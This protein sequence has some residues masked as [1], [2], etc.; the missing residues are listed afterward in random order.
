MDVESIRQLNNTYN[1]KYV[2]YAIENIQMSN[3][4][5]LYQLQNDLID[6]SRFDFTTR[7]I[8]RMFRTP[9]I[10][11]KGRICLKVPK[12]FIKSSVKSKFKRSNLYNQRLTIFDI[13]SKS[14]F[15]YSC[16]L[17]ID[18][19]LY[20]GIELY[21]TDDF[22]YIVFSEEVGRRIL[23]LE[24]ELKV[25]VII[26]PNF[27]IMTTKTN[28]YKIQKTLIE[29][30]KWKFPKS[31]KYQFIHT[32]STDNITSDILV[33]NRKSGELTPSSKIS[34]TFQGEEF[35]INSIGMQYLSGSIVV[36]GQTYFSIPQQNMP[37]VSE[38]M[39]IFK[40]TDNG[41]IYDHDAYVESFYPNIYR[42][43]GHDSSKKYYILFFY[44][45]EAGYDLYNKL[46]YDR[47]FNLLDRINYDVL[48]GYRTNTLPDIIKNYSPEEAVYTINEYNNSSFTEPLDYK[49]D[50]LIELIEKDS[51]NSS[52]YFD[53][54]F[55]GPRKVYLD[56]STV[57]LSTRERMNTVS[58]TPN[59]KIYFNT[60]H[61]V[62]VFR[63]G[64]FDDPFNIRIFIDGLVTSFHTITDNNYHTY[65]YLPCDCVAPTSIIEF[66]TFKNVVID[67]EFT[68]S[69]GEAILELKLP[70]INIMFSNIVITTLDG[71][72]IS[73]DDYDI[74]VKKDSQFINLNDVYKTYIT[75][76]F[77][78]K[79]SDNSFNGEKLL[80]KVIHQSCAKYQVIETEDNRGNAIYFKNPISREKGCFRIFRN[81]KLVPNEHYDIKYRKNINSEIGIDIL[82]DKQVG[83]IIIADILPFDYN[84]V[85]FEELI[86]ENGYVDLEGYLDRPMSLKW[87]DVYLNGRKLNLFNIDIISPTKIFIQGV[88]SRKN[89]MIVEIKRDPEYF[90]IKQRWNSFN[91]E[92]WENFPNLKEEIHAQHSILEDSEVDFIEEH[93]IPLSVDL[94]RF[95]EY[96]L[97][98]QTYINA[99]ETNIPDEIYDQFDLMK[100]DDV[101]VIDPDIYFGAPSIL[102]VF[103]ED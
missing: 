78:I 83:D 100:V 30:S 15:Q 31:N 82:I 81:G 7:D 13:E 5:Y 72:I 74:L 59:N 47:R 86:S 16:L 91:D 73:Y 33:T 90:S 1:P 79:F 2:Q 43:N 12:D 26:C 35:V 25:S 96:Y 37:I 71:E 67:D 49:D 64:I 94:D 9:Y 23:R 103:N 58:E 10:P 99:D 57:D 44:Y 17:F 28:Y 3:Y 87:Y 52:K 65:V 24:E 102:E 38:N 27:K 84:V 98:H 8:K 50:K 21:P 62:F 85:Y 53:L 68:V 18:G 66:E 6:Y 80:L 19:I 88:T 56:V 60:P 89:L 97:K 11:L 69:N 29:E 63:N 36:S 95:Y 93:V 40:K 70:D 42:L 51:T 48:N 92:L 20:T 32:L 45:D 22:T 76:E 77:K 41:L 14:E 34:T 54:Q 101:I 55:R 75:D 46:I 61:Y 39:L 4:H